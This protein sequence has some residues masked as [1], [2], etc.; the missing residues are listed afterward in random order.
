MQ[1]EPGADVAQV[2]FFVAPGLMASTLFAEAHLRTDAPDVREQLVVTGALVTVSPRGRW[3]AGRLLGGG[4][5]GAHQADE[6]RPEDDRC[7]PPF[8][9]PPPGPRPPVRGQR[10]C[11]WRSGAAHLEEDSG[12]SKPPRRW[13]RD[14]RAESVPLRG[15]VEAVE[16]G[17]A[18]ER[19]IV[20][21]HI[22]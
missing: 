8:H 18:S 17:F 21:P 11:T 12:T 19:L 16:L 2:S 7:A 15:A 9:P 1:G 6:A 13:L 22:Q 10:D 3:R 14:G 4:G 5:D 20:D